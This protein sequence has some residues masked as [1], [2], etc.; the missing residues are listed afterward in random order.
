M[1]RL[2]VKGDRKGDNIKSDE[3]DF[4]G[5]TKMKP[6]TMKAL[7]SDSDEDTEESIDNIIN[8]NGNYT[9][10]KSCSGSNCYRQSKSIYAI[11]IK[12]SGERSGS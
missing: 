1:S 9:K 2:K 4:A 8:D 10:K 7:E 5:S 12:Q 6:P 3:D 11:E